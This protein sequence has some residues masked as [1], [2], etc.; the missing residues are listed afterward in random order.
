MAVLVFPSIKKLGFIVA[1]QRGVGALIGSGGHTRGYYETV[2]G[3]Y[4]FQ[5]GVQA[6]GY[7]LFFLDQGSLQYLNGAQGWNVA[8]APA[9]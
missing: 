2:G 3:S 4:G 7:A 9:S 5:A 8:N 1:V 6:Y